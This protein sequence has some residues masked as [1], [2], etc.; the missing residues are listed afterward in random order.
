[1]PKKRHIKKLCENIAMLAWVG[2]AI[3]GL[4]SRVRFLCQD[5][6]RI[7][8]KTIS[9]KKI[10][11]KGI[12][13]IGQVQWQFKAT[14]IY[15]VVEPQTGE[16][17]FY[18]FTHLNTDCFQAFLELVSAKFAGELLIIQL[19]NGAFH[20]AKRL[21]VPSNII[22]LFQPPYTPELNPI[23]RLLPRAAKARV[24]QHLKRGLRWKLPRNLEELREMMKNR[25]E[26]MTVEVIASIVGW[27]YIL[28]ALSVAGI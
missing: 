1:M 14:Y 17:L 8:L 7:G 3:M 26:E 6:T 12:K 4:G 9:G 28:D 2:V 20:K 22:L 13:P 16:N 23:E 24:W 10:T 5:E 25:L 21:Q 18:E 27:D 11:G 19:D 15:G